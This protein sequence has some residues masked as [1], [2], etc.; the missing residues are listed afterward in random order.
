MKLIPALFADLKLPLQDQG[1]QTRFRITRAL[2]AT[3]D[4]AQ[5]SFPH[6]GDNPSARNRRTISSFQAHRGGDEFSL[7]HQDYW[8]HCA[9][10][11]LENYWIE[12][13]NRQL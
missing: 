12:M 5:A 11:G 8:Q 4:G 3:F 10:T 13:Q 1:S 9:A 7:I 6:M 2:F